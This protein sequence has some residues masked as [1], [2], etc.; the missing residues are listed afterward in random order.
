MPVDDGIRV[1]AATFAEHPPKVSLAQ[2]AA[3]DA[4]FYVKDHNPVNIK[5]REV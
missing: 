1:M 4:T 3:R 5:G 2:E